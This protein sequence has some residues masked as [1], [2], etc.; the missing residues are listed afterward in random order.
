MLGILRT[1]RMSK[2]TLIDDPEAMTSQERQDLIDQI[3]KHPHFQGVTGPTGPIGPPG[4]PGLG[5]EDILILIDQRIAQWFDQLGEKLLALDK[6]LDKFAQ[7]ENREER[8]EATQKVNEIMDFIESLPLSHA[9][10]KDT[11][12]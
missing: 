1:T 10:N 11:R 3:A 9:R 12:P 6:A 4:Q 8:V 7:F 5:K 2:Q